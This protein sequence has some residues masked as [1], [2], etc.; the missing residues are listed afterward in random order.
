[1][2]YIN[3]IIFIDHYRILGKH[4]TC[5]FFE[6]F[7]NTAVLED[8]NLLEDS[9]DDNKIWS[10]FS[11]YEDEF[12]ESL[13]SFI[14]GH[15]S[16]TSRKLDI[17]KV[18]RFFAEQFLSARPLWDLEDF[19]LVWNRSFSEL[20]KPDL[21]CISDMI[22]VDKHPGSGRMEIRKYLRTDLPSEVEARF[23]TLF[24]T[25]P[26]WQYEDLVPFIQ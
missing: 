19:M 9:L 21:K 5:R 23:I 10:I 26:R 1:M 18:M 20:F 12:T 15:Y 11:Q 13:T 22:L 17:V 16:D 8:W 24:K 6:L 3:I 2:I 14:L 25:K 7:F 4:L